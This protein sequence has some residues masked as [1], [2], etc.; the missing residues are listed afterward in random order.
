MKQEKKKSKWLFYLINLLIIMVVSLLTIYK[1]V[2]E[3][4]KETLMYLKELS[5][6]SICIL[7]VIFLVNYFLEGIIISLSIKDS[8]KNFTPSNGFVIQ[9][10]GGLFSAITPL[11]CGYLPSVAYAYSKYGVKAESIIKSM[12]KTSLTYQVV[13]LLIS[14]ISIIIFSSNNFTITI[15]DTELNLFFVALIGIVY[16]V[17][18]M[19]GYFII[20]LS[21]A[22]HNLV[23]KVLAWFLYKIKKINDKEVY[24]NEQIYKMN[25]IRKQ[26]KLFFKDI[27]QFIILTLIYIFKIVFFSGL[28]YIAYLLLS[29][30]SF[31]INMWLFSIILC[32]LISYITNI[33]PIPGASGAAEIAFV[34][35]YSLIF[36]SSLLT[37]TMLVWR[38]FSYFINI[39]VGFI[40][41][42]I[43]LNFKKKKQENIIE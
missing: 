13:C 30:D 10:V 2:G 14:I 35:V 22:L 37:S 7:T 4:G 23:L 25:L 16:N 41:F 27:K 18:L 12:A 17:V 40:V 8:E 36:P 32:N 29:N 21:P 42:V 34:G 19:L 33:I 5:V 1:I 24:L 39:I 31:D 26:I 20:V 3:N 28:P 15:G 38:M 11:K 9:S 6:V 43:I